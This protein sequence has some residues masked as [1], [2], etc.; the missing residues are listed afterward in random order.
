MSRLDFAPKI[1]DIKVTDIKR[2]LGVFTPKPGRAASFAALKAT[3]KKA[4]YALASAEIIVSG[5]LVKDEKG[6]WLE[7]D[8]SKQRFA[9]VG[10]DSNKLLEGAGA[11]ARVE[12]AGGW[13]TSAEGS[14]TRESIS[15][16]SAKKIAAKSVEH[17]DRKLALSAIQI[18]LG[19]IGGGPGM[20]FAPIRTTSPGLTVY[21]GGAVMS[22]YF[23]TSQ[24][25][26]NLEVDRHGL[27]LGFSYTPTTTLQLEAE[28]PY[29]RTSFDDGESSGSGQGAGNLTLWGKYRFYRALETWGDRQAAV[30][31]GLELPTGKK[32]APGEDRL[33]ATEF[34]RQQLSPINGG[35]A[36][37]FDL[38]YSQA[39]HRLLYGANIEGTLRSQRDGFRAGH[40]LRIN[41]DLEYVL[42]PLKYRS[43]TKELFVILETTTVIENRGRINGR[44]VPGSS[45]TA[46][47][48]APALQYVATARLIFEASLQLPVIQ[49]MGPQMLRTDK[50]FL[51]GLRY[52][53]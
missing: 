8:E 6:W 47:Y 29:S 26:G 16:R 14:T 22:R 27:R 39:K 25:L 31:F 23:F 28:I 51:I 30:R 37:R 4:G 46:F 19:G 17:G 36:A 44:E 38:A 21:R 42:L 50:S 10:D 20:A 13:Q 49:N 52:L 2:G 11:G 5:T 3:L 33:D 45:S 48:L 40:E 43:P 32:R 34:V 1:N 7:V 9:I 12:V 18:S 15:L 41:T 24:H 35:L 53:Y